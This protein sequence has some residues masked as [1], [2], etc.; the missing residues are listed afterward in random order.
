M[1]TLSLLRHVLTTG[2]SIAGTAV[3]PYS[4]SD[5]ARDHRLTALLTDPHRAQRV[6]RI[7]RT[8]LDAEDVLALI[9]AA[10]GHELDEGGAAWRQR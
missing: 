8:G 1:P 10:A 4:D 6:Q 2:S 9:E 7:K 5:L 3:G